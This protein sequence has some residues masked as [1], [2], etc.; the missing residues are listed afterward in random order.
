MIFDRPPQ[1]AASSSP[2]LLTCSGN[3]AWVAGRARGEGRILIPR[4]V[5]QFKIFGAV[6]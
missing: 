3:R 2:G 4:P 1:L 5:S 6:I